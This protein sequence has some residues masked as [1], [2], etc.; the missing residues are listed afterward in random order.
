ME[1]SRQRRPLRAV[2]KIASHAGEVQ[3]T[4]DP[5]GNGSYA[6]AAEHC[7]QILGLTRIRCPPLPEPSFIADYAR[8]VLRTDFPITGKLRG[9]LLAVTLSGASAAPP[10]SGEKRILQDK[11]S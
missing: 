8:H 9:K 4:S 1:E 5:L 11:S 10:F 2:D 6:H 7:V 3:C